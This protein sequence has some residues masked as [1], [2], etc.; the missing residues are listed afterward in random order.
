MFK[1]NLAFLGLQKYLFFIFSLF[2]AILLL[3]V[4]SIIYY[5][6]FWY[7][8]IYNK[9]EHKKSFIKYYYQWLDFNSGPVMIKNIQ[10]QCR[11][12]YE[13]LDGNLVH[14]LQLQAP[15]DLSIGFLLSLHF[16]FLISPYFQ[17]QFY[18]I[19][20]LSLNFYFENLQLLKIMYEEKIFMNISTLR[21]K[22]VLTQFAELCTVPLFIIETHS[23]S[24]LPIHWFPSKYQQISEPFRLFFIYLKIK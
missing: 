1:A 17:L 23:T 5:Y 8:F 19:L 16:S 21:M 22:V 9:H 2:V 3:Y 24:S 6:I 10:G 20:K 18:H 4:I 7:D 11:F 12:F 15:V 13:H 14:N